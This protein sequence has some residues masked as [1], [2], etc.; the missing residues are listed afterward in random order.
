MVTLGSSFFVDAP[1]H[2]Q[3]LIHNLFTREIF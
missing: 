3:P 2:D 1:G